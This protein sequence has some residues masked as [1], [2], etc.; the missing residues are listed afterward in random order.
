M[1]LPKYSERMGSGVEWLGE[2]PAH[3]E[4][5]PMKRLLEIQNGADYKHVETDDGYPVIGSGGQFTW[6]SEYLYDGES[7]LLGRKGTIDKPLYVNG[8]FWTV[9]TMYWSKIRPT[10]SGRFAYYV[11]TT[12]PF[13]YY[14]TNTALPS[15]TQSALG[16]HAIAKPLLD[17]Q[18][19]IA[20]FLDR[21][22]AKID[23][24]IAEQVQLLT[25]LAEK[26]Q[27]IVSHIV[28]RGLNPTVTMK[29]SG[30][31]WLGEVPTHWGAVRLG[32]LCKQVSDGPHF[33]PSYVDDGVMFISARNI[34]VDGWS[35]EDAKYVSEEDYVEFC[36]RVV[37]KIGDVLYTKGGTTGIARV[38]DLQERFQVWVHVAVLK[39]DK[40][41]ALPH[42]V[43]YALNSLGCYEQSQLYTRGA[44][45][46]DLGLTR[47]IR[48]LLALPPMEEQVSIVTFLDGKVA[49]L[50][51]LKRKAERAI[52]L[53]KER[54]SAL[55]SAA[56]TGKIDVRS[57]VAP[58]EFA[59]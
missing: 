41:L 25:L 12:I 31:S 19:Q 2:L 33:S 26:R 3:W 5:A 27:A 30:I 23:A 34:R 46:Q 37:P 59:A 10:A 17:E 38:V 40:D 39:L 54:R 50:D 55:I 36:K 13:A 22:T 47:M 35:L 4:V 48:I 7:V 52:E 53:L 49:K 57:F 16:N 44:T 56:V 6:A 20:A 1:S 28:T 14:S 32:R 15:M 43:A 51:E 24:L 29:D 18:R 58:E 9:D 42:F 8:K 45:N 11:A 21:E